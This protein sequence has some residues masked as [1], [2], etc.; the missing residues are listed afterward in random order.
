ML[1]FRFGLQ[2]PLLQPFMDTIRPFYPPP[3][4][5]HFLTHPQP[6]S[7]HP[8]PN[9]F[10]PP[11]APHESKASDITDQSRTIFQSSM[12][13]NPHPSQL[14]PPPPNPF[15]LHGYIPHFPQSF[16]DSSALWNRV[17]SDEL[18][19]L[20]SRLNL[21]QI[22]SQKSSESGKKSPC[23]GNRS[24]AQCSQTE[25]KVVRV[26]AVH[27]VLSVG[28][29]VQSKSDCSQAI[30][31]E[32][33]SSNSTL[34]RIRKFQSENCEDNN[35]LESDLT[36]RVPV[37]NFP[38]FMTSSESCS[39]DSFPLLNLL[40]KYS[41]GISTLSQAERILSLLP[42]DHPLRRDFELGVRKH[43]TIQSTFRRDANGNLSSVF[44]NNRTVPLDSHELVDSQSESSSVD[45]EDRPRKVSRS[46]DGNDPPLRSTNDGRDEE[47]QKMQPLAFWPSQRNSPQETEVSETTEVFKKLPSFNL[48]V[49]PQ[50]DLFS[51]SIFPNQPQNSISTDVT[52]T[53][54]T[55]KCFPRFHF[56]S[57]NSQD[58]HHES[59]GSGSELI[60]PITLS[61]VDESRIQAQNTSQGM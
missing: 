50:S 52:A 18:V 37:S 6:S 48:N 40:P 13:V 44:E 4:H 16:L 43:E 47:Y 19:K 41:D 7:F 17:T 57:K 12:S 11:L 28:N 42:F 23:N 20:G 51:T 61:C 29:L 8:H 22:S 46:P 54:E 34:E 33:S 59:Q 35:M 36:P 1:C 21:D 2:F 38:A 31:L 27:A 39:S 26:P 14:P 49:R 5:P 24:P 60:R 9:P 25:N 58:I 53:L 10:L 3:P 15:L 32:D 55:A 45:I 30:K 56:H